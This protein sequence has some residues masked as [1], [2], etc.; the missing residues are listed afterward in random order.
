V[1][2]AD[3]AFDER[4]LAAPRARDGGG[5]RAAGQDERREDEERS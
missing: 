1:E 5:E 3:A 4:P 2:Q